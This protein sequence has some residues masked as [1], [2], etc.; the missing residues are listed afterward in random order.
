MISLLP[1]QG[2]RNGV[3]LHG[4]VSVGQEEPRPS[5]EHLIP[6]SSIIL[7]PRLRDYTT[8]AKIP[9]SS[10]RCPANDLGAGTQGL[11]PQGS[12]MIKPSQPQLGA[13]RSQSQSQQ[14]VVDAPRMTSTHTENGMDSESFAQVRGF[15]PWIR[16]CGEVCAPCTW[17][18]I[19][20]G[21]GTKSERGAT[22][23]VK[24]SWD[25]CWGISDGRVEGS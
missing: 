10:A 11:P 21:C 19:C 3:R 6:D 2:V 8:A 22:V 12:E 4:G 5:T 1:C 13:A 25:G 17:M 20:D 15:S 23:G 14:T 16:D 9:S 7:I 18:R 24:G